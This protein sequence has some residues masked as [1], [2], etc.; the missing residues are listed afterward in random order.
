MA[1]LDAYATFEEYKAHAGLKVDT[2]AA[3][4]GSLL[5]TASRLIEMWTDR[6][7]NATA[8]GVARYFDGNGERELYVD[9]L[10]AFTALAFDTDGDGVYETEITVA[11]AVA[12]PRNNPEAGK[13]YTSLL[14]LPAAECSVFPAAADSVQLTGTYGWPA[15]PGAIRDYT[16]VIARQLRD[17][18]E[19]GVTLTIEAADAALQ[20][21]PGAFSLINAIREGYSRTWGA[22]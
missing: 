11:Q 19:S 16:I 10:T 22:V 20:V 6:S 17:I 1:L 14:L 13:P 4:V 9:D 7:F 3:R 8:A 18:Q 12:R 2:D 21:R 5:L 15:V